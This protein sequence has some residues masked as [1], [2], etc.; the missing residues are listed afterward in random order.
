MVTSIGLS[1]NDVGKSALGV[2]RVS[3]TKLNA[4]VVPPAIGVN[5]NSKGSA[6]AGV[7]TNAAAA[8]ASPA[9]RLSIIRM[10]I[11]PRLVSRRLTN[12]ALNYC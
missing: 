11:L 9:N 8:M 2:G 4:G 7:E 3:V 6:A 5:S 10:T 12:V 1:V